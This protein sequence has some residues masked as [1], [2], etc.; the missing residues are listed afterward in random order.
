MLLQFLETLSSLIRWLLLLEIW[1]IQTNFTPEVP[2]ANALQKLVKSWENCLTGLEQWF[3][4]AH[5][6][7][8]ALNKAEG[9]HWTIKDAR[10]DYELHLMLNQG[11]LLMEYGFKASYAHVWRGLESTKEKPQVPYDEG[12]NQLP[13][14]FKQIVENN[15]G[16]LSRTSEIFHQ[17]LVSGSYKVDLNSGQMSFF[18]QLGK[19]LYHYCSDYFT[20]DAF[21]ST[22]SNS[23]NPFATAVMAVQKKSSTI[24][25]RP[26]ALRHVSV[27]PK[28]KKN[29]NIYMD[30]LSGYCN[31]ASAKEPGTIRQTSHI[32]S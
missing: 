32:F 14:L 27:T 20:V 19:S 4:N 9:C 8:V 29:K 30:P 17:R 5:D 21:W 31:A 1:T 3:N 24:E 12:Y 15:P 13:S 7:C 10:K 28:R 25:V 23:I 18:K 6:F 16:N 2:N 26:P 22:Y 11:K